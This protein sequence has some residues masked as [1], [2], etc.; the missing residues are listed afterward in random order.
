MT[1]LY[2]THC[3]KCRVLETKLGQNGIEYKVIDDTDVVI[4]VGRAHGIMSAPILFI[5]DQY[6]DFSAAIKYINE[7]N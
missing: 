6:Y 3:P 5:D 1:I 2:T 4:D 7:R